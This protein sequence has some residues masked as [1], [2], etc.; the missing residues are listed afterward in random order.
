[1]PV[2]G[3]CLASDGPLSRLPGHVQCPGTCAA[4]AGLAKPAS[5]TDEWPD[6]SGSEEARR[7]G[8]DGHGERAARCGDGECRKVE[9]ESVAASRFFKA[10]EGSS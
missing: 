10:V 1:M 3:L 2:P 5:G 9:S 7:L 6:S 4:A 8:G